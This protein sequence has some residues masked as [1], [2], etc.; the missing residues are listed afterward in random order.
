MA[1]DRFFSPVT[2]SVGLNMPREVTS[3]REAWEFLTDWPQSRRGPVH[4]TA[5]RACSAAMAGNLSTENARRAF[6]GFAKVYGILDE[7][8]VPIAPWT[9]APQDTGKGGIPI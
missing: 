4:A 6:V 9:S 5:L 7:D 3:L 2:V 8:A 1:K